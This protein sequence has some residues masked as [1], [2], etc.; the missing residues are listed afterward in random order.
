MILEK[1]FLKKNKLC[2][3]CIGRL[4]KK[5]LKNIDL[6][7]FG[8]KLRLKHKIKKIEIKKCSLC[9]GL[10]DEIDDF[11]KI[12][13]KKIKN[14]EFETFLIGTKIDQDISEIEEKYLKILNVE[15][16]L[17][18]KNE[19]NKQI[20]LKLEKKLNK[21]VDFN[22][23]NIMIILDTQFNNVVLQI[24]SLFIFGRYKKFSRKIPQTKWFCKI[25]KGKG[26]RNCNYKGTKYDTSVEEI[27]SKFFLDKTKSKDESFHGAGR[28]D[29]DVKML[30]NGRPFVLELKNPEIRNINLKNL[31][32]KIN[33]NFLEFVEVSNLKFTNRKKISEIKKARYK[34]V[35]DVTIKSKNL[36]NI[37]K[38]KKVTQSLQGKTIKQKTPSRVAHRRADMVR[39]KHIYDI[40]IIQVEE[41]IA[42][43]VI[44]TESGTYIK[45][46]IS[47][48]DGKTEP[49]ISGLLKS[50]CMV[51]KLDVI[52]I[53]G[54]S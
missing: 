11:I 24:E 51:K 42:R 49:S 27:I 45:E 31:E 4:F 6:E 36:I 20:G 13:Y 47:G 46:L 25:C 12:I 26:C 29:I 48:D 19:I 32:N 23:P 21:L 8:K 10:L 38:L 43:L 37:E 40:Q 9:N 7:E 3:N 50:P 5:N 14:Y 22:K 39:I 54:E 2:D 30:G 1:D 15:N 34:K 44:E 16:Y 52:K 53:K 41:T 28:E 35:Y 17:Y 18:L 33:K